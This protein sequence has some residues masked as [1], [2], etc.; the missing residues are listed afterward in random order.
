MSLAAL[1]LALAL[2][3]DL[4]GI[5]LRLGAYTRVSLTTASTV[6]L[7][8]GRSVERRTGVRVRFGDPVSSACRERSD[9]RGEREAADPS[10]VLLIV[11]VHR[12]LNTIRAVVVAKRPGASGATE[13]ADLSGGPSA[14]TAVLDGMAARLFPERPRDKTDDKTDRLLAPAP[15]PATSG[16]LKPWMLAAAAGATA[17][18]IGIPFGLENRKNRDALM[19]VPADQAEIDRLNRL[20]QT[21]GLIADALFVA[22]LFG[23]GAA[24][25]LALEQD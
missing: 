20:Q 15:P 9:C 14:W 19:S 7:E 8:V 16:W 13:S 6:A 18:A 12:G 4:R 23:A 5:E 22:A 11:H 1:V 2:P 24:I 10:S 17:G 21:Q 25:W 3:A